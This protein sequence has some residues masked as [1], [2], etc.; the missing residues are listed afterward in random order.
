M[1]YMRA[2]FLAEEE[3]ENLS[4][5]MLSLE[6]MRKCRSPDHLRFMFPNYSALEPQT[7]SQH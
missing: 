5:I 6:P 4:S 2:S 3:E 1:A 7:L